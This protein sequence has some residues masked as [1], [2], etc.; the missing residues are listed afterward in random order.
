MWRC[1]DVG[2]LLC[3]KAPQDV[4]KCLLDF[5]RPALP[6]AAAGRLETMHGVAAR[7]LV[8]GWVQ[9]VMP[10]FVLVFFLQLACLKSVAWCWMFQAGFDRELVGFFVVAGS[11]T[12]VIR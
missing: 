5:T 10:A 11:V 3:L 8:W 9:E 4:A 7:V 6:A 1:S 2:S 12:V